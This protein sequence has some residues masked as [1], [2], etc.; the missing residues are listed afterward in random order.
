MGEKEKYINFNR[1]GYMLFT[2]GG[3]FVA[4]L[5]IASVIPIFY[6]CAE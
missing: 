6:V 5:M 1:Y 3:W 4:L 2:V